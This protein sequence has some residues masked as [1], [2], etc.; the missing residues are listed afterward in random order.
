MS[1][2]KALILFAAAAS[3]AVLSE[4]QILT[5]SQ[6]CSDIASQIDGDVYSSP[7]SLNYIEDSEHYMS[8]S[9]QAPTCVVEVESPEDISTILE[10]VASSRTPFAVKSG[11]HASNQGFSSTTG[12]Q[13]SLVRLNQVTLSADKSTV[14]IG[15]GNV[16]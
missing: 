4:R 9:S 15:L 11:G 3:A 2:I 1:S 16:S 12:V 14:E 8:S 7:L 13:I 5:Q 6:V 10:I